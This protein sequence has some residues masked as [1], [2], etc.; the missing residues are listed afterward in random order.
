[1]SDLLLSELKLADVDDEVDHPAEHLVL[2]VRALPV[3]HQDVKHLPGSWVILLEPEHPEGHDGVVPPVWLVE[4]GDGELGA[5]VPDHG[6]LPGVGPLLLLAVRSAQRPAA[7]ATSVHQT[8]VTISLSRILSRVMSHLV[9]SGNTSDRW[10]PGCCR[11]PWQPVCP[12]MCH[13][14]MGTHIDDDSLHLE[15]DLPGGNV[16]G[17][18]QHPPAPLLEVDVVV[19][20][21]NEAP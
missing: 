2:S 7:V 17:G 11:P 19:E 18:D 15:D 4:V 8:C 21:H 16:S 3:V 12:G 6:A 10:G 5:G 13:G 20:S 9:I 1:M 14:V